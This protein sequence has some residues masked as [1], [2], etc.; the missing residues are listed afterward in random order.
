MS[1][2]SK[3]NNTVEPRQEETAFMFLRALEGQAPSNVAEMLRELTLLLPQGGK[4]RHPL[5]EP[6]EV[7]LFVAESTETG[8]FRYANIALDHWS[9]HVQATIQEI[10]DQ[11]PVEKDARLLLAEL[12][13]AIQR[14]RLLKPAEE[15][16][17]ALHNK[18][19][20]SD[21]TAIYNKIVIPEGSI[22]ER[23]PDL[24][25]SA[26]EWE[27]RAR[28]RKG[29]I[30]N[31]RLSSGWPHFDLAQTGPK[32]KHPGFFS[33]GQLAGFV[34]P[35]GH[36]KSTFVRELVRNI[37]LDLR[38]WGMPHAKVLAII[39]EEEPERVSEA[40]RLAEDYRAAGSQVLIAKVNSSRERFGA[41][42]FKAVADAVI[43]ADLAG[44]PVR[45]FMPTVV[46]LDYL[47]EIVEAG[48]NAYT[49]A[50]EKTVGVMR[51]MAECDPDEIAK[52]S[53]IR[54]SDVAPLGM[55]WP[56]DI[57][58]HKV[59]VIATAQVKGLKEETLYYDP[60]SMSIEEFTIRDPGT[61][62]PLWLPEKGDHRVIRRG[63]V[64]GSKKFLNNLSTLV[65]LH[66][67][68]PR[69]GRENYERE[70]LDGRIVTAPRLSDTRARFIFEKQRYGAASPVVPMAFTAAPD[71]RAAK[72]YDP[73][74]EQQ[75][76]AEIK[77]GRRVKREWGWDW[78]ADWYNSEIGG[79][80]LPKRSLRH[81]AEK[82][83]Y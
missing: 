45:E 54:F 44:Q 23:F 53:G 25:A 69:A 72:W 48:E 67:S 32:D 41:A 81:P 63:D 34:A 27:D 13:L 3:N 24:V 9:E 28:A 49:D 46:L 35:S 52:F 59:A 16:I 29:T 39:V 22:E 55:K 42:F 21:V 68:N 11:P 4:K 33:P 38:N 77:Y 18:V 82:L 75:V 62:E 5:V 79:P 50:I 2:T 20:M 60:K 76:H 74:A 10:V 26:I 65:F 14:A 15:L 61:G 6:I 70:L 8:A 37:A 51:G 64:A 12:K 57:A 1:V 73:L 80:L 71:G 66:R 17:A 36:G 83:T 19:P 78:D 58:D 7:L 31:L 30:D 47:Q 43:E 56:A 40:A